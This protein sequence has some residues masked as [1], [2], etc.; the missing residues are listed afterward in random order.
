M[1]DGS[2]E[3]IFITEEQQPMQHVLIGEE[4][5]LEP[6]QGDNALLAVDLTNHTSNESQ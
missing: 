2:T 3:T 1:S 5:S 6:P 4:T